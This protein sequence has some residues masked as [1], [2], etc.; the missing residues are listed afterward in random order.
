M[1]YAAQCPSHG[2]SVVVCAVDVSVSSSSALL[3]LVCDDALLSEQLLEVLH[4][5]RH[6]A[7]PILLFV[8]IPTET[9]ARAEIVKT[10]EKAQESVAVFHT[11][12]RDAAAHVAN[13]ELTLPSKQVRHAF[14]LEHFAAREQHLRL[15]F[16]K[17]A[18]ATRHRCSVLLF[19][20][21]TIASPATLEVAMAARGALQPQ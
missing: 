12:R 8:I 15:L 14:L 13:E 4:I 2:R 1:H 16:R 9:A 6:N 11:L 18:L 3:A 17:C 20:I 7:S 10:V 21:F 5:A 19:V